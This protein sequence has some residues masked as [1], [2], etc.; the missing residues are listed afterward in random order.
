MFAPIGRAAELLENKASQS[1]T[2][3]SAAMDA[4]LKISDIKLSI[5]T[6]SS[7]TQR[8]Y[9]KETG[10][11]FFGISEIPQTHGQLPTKSEISCWSNVINESNPDLIMV[12][13]TECSNGLA[14]L[15][16]AK[17]I[18]TIFY[19]QGVLGRNFIYPIG[20]LRFLDIAKLLSPL[21]LIK[22]LY[23]K[24]NEKKQRKN[25]HIEKLIVKKS[26]GLIMDNEWE[27]S[28]YRINCDFDNI[29][30]WPLPIK[31]C[32]FND[33]HNIKDCK[34]HSIFTID[35]RYPGKGVH[36][37]IKAVAIVK[38][39][40]PDVKVI[41]P[42]SMPNRKPELIF[43]SPYYT[44][45]KKLIK[46]LDLQENVVFCGQISSEDVKNNLLSCNAFVMTSCYESQSAALREAM[47]LGVPAITSNVGP[48]DEYTVSGSD[49][50]TYR[51]GEID[52]L[53]D[54]IIRIFESDDLATKL[55]DNAFN[56]IRK[57]YPQ[58]N[59]GEEL[60]KIYDEVINTNNHN[61]L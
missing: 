46:K 57:H 52:V 27:K 60:K 48:I 32:F 13:G 47:Y 50:L 38:K 17:K 18:P 44:Y 3:I 34:R 23:L 55:G 41:I 4:L 39:K 14:I 45:L 1:G 16:A 26:S 2:W 53:A 43:E 25:I 42:G 37:L 15:E 10:V 22:F 54:S 30:H 24:N 59:I 40:Y 19:I 36:Q 5:A 8:I 12:W 58:D 9:D 20:Q 61:S 49:V 56:S 29:F 31:Q 21:S 6:I 7:K 11:E 35:G 51:Y 33:K 28:Y